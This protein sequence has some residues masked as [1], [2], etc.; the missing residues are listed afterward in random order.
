MNLLSQFFSRRLVYTADGRDR[1]VSF[2]LSRED[3][4]CSKTG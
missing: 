2:R 1:S 4:Q 3:F